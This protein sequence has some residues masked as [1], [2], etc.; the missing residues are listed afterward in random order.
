MQVDRLS[1][2][3]KAYQQRADQRQIARVA[4]GKGVSKLEQKI[5]VHQTFKQPRLVAVLGRLVK[6]FPNSWVTGSDRCRAI[7]IICVSVFMT[8][9]VGPVAGVLQ[10]PEE[11][12]Q[13]ELNTIFFDEN[14]S[15]LIWNEGAL[16]F[17]RHRERKGRAIHAFRALYPT[18]S[19]VSVATS[20]LEGS[21]FSCNRDT[22]SSAT[23]CDI[24]GFHEYWLTPLFLPGIK[25]CLSKQERRLEIR[26]V[27]NPNIQDLFISQSSIS[28]EC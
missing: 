5:A 9:C 27:G 11:F 22:S 24:S 4:R 25:S 23:D 14:G 15:F 16:E 20:D 8:A 19:E 12:S 18:N 28:L 7:C 3:K 6:H 1:S 17:D 2:L 13:S 10:F 26:L 21:G